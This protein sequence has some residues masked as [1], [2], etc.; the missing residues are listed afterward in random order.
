MSALCLVL[1]SVSIH[2]ILSQDAKLCIK[3]VPFELLKQARPLFLLIFK[4]Q[5]GLHHHNFA[6]LRCDF[7]CFLFKRF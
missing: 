7:I 6:I 4:P 1:C 3:I 5:K 2:V